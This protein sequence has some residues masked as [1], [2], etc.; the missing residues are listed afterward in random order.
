M[1]D[2]D[3]DKLGDGDLI[4]FDVFGLVDRRNQFGQL[5]L[6]LTLGPAK[7]VKLC[8]SFARLFVTAGVE[9]EPKRIFAALLNV[10][11][12]DACPVIALFLRKENF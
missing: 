2:A 11:L 3:A 9:F 5:D 10:T 7:R 12:H 6:R 4:R 8:F 1:V